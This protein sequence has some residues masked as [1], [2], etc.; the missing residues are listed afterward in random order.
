MYEELLEYL[1]LTACRLITT[2]S[3]MRRTINEKGG[4]TTT[5][6]LQPSHESEERY[7]K[8][9]ATCKTSPFQSS[10]I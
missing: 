2:F 6:S 8:S 10:T 3:G 9:D 7:S 5:T 4:F 1:E